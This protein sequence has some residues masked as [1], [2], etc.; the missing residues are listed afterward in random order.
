MKKIL[1]L[2]VCC[3]S[4]SAAFAQ[5]EEAGFAEKLFKACIA[6]NRDAF[7]AF[8]PTKEQLGRYMKESV[9]G[10]TITPQ[11]LT[12]AYDFQLDK[13]LLGYNTFQEAV[14]A[15]G[16]NPKDC[17][18]T[19]TSNEISDSELKKGDK[20]VGLAKSKDIVVY[21]TS[22]KKNYAFLVSGAIKIDGKWYLGS[23]PVGISDLNK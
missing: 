15:L 17:K 11:M 8:R 2:L 14:A 20:V 16:I 5:M 23:Q 3:L 19:N 6:D 18:V 22:G 21:F 13:A 9:P 4:V 12:G 1:L 7:L 10:D